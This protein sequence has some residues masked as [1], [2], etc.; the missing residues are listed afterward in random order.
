MDERNG[1]SVVTTISFVAFLVLGNVVGLLIGA[2][3]G[4][5]SLK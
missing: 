3:L 4:L 2:Q 5:I 1:N